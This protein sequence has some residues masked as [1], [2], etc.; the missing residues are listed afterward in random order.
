MGISTARLGT[1]TVGSESKQADL[2]A[3]IAPVQVLTTVSTHYMMFLIMNTH[4]FSFSGSKD[5]IFV[6][7]INPYLPD[8]LITAGV[9]HM[10][11]W[12]KA[13]KTFSLSLS[14]S[15]LCLSRLRVDSVIVCSLVR[16][17]FNW[18]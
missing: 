15:L 14:L 9:K 3:T 8:K 7:K 16:W 1:E 6:I 11:F 4:E 2:H 5:K 13:G 10:K 12:H 18:A 17:W